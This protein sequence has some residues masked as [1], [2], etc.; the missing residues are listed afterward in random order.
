MRLVT[1]IF[2]PIAHNRLLFFLIHFHFLT[3]L[4]QRMTAHHIVEPIIILETK[5]YLIQFVTWR[6]MQIRVVHF[7]CQTVH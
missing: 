1:D 5:Y 6:V 2:A 4:P 3:K 7:T